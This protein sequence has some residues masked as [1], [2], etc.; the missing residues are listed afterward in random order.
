VC[1]YAAKILRQNIV[2]IRAIGHLALFFVGFVLH[3]QRS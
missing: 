1:P 3:E 2:Y